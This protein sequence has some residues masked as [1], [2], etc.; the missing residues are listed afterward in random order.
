MELSDG[1]IADMNSRRLETQ[2]TMILSP[3]VTL[4]LPR[5]SKK[6]RSKLS[7]PDTS[8]EGYPGLLWI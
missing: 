2:S 1:E 6:V 7:D 3:T 4:K 5:D 8:V